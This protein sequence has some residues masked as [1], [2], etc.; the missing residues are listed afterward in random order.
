MHGQLGCTGTR[1]QGLSKA[2]DT[3]G[4]LW[5]WQEE[6]SVDSNCL[7]G[8]DAP[9]QAITRS[10]QNPVRGHGLLRQRKLEYSFRQQARSQMHIHSGWYA[11]ASLGRSQ[12]VLWNDG[13][14]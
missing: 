7:P 4:L 14:R 2:R 10:H 12:E 1:Q 6:E 3:A 11:E 9:F 8:Q 5:E 13:M